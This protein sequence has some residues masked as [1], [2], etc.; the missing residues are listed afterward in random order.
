MKSMELTWEEARALALPETTSSGPQWQPRSK[1]KSVPVQFAM[2]S[3]TDN[4]ESHCIHNIPGL[5]W[6]RVGIDLFENAGQTCLLV[7]DFYSKYFKIELLCQNTASCVINN[8]E[9]M[10]ARFG[11]PDKVVSDNGSQYSNTSNPFAYMY[12]SHTCIFTII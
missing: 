9:K 11:V 1:T 2:P 6:K 8:L 5:P 7:T 12:F 10:F 3:I 4:K